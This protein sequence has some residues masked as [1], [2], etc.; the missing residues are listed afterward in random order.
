MKTIK[1]S[2]LT[3]LLGM[4]YYPQGATASTTDQLREGIIHYS[5]LNDENLRIGTQK[6]EALYK[7]TLDHKVRDDLITLLVR[8]GRYKDAIA[9]CQECQLTQ[10]SA[11]EL[12]HLAKAARN[13]RQFELAS[14]FYTQ[15]S[16][17]A[18]DNPNGILGLALVSIERPDYNAANH[19]LAKYKKQFGEDAQYTEAYIYLLDSSQP[20]TAR[21]T[22]WQ[23]EL[24]QHP[25]NTELAKKIYR[26][27]TQLNISP[28]QEKLVAA[29]PDLFNENDKLWFLHDEAIRLY[30]VATTRE[31][32]KTAYRMLSDANSR[33][34]SDD[35]GELKLQIMRDMVVVASKLQ[36]STEI[37]ATYAQLQQSGQPI[38]AFVKEAYA[39]Y[40][41][42]SG[43]PFSAL[44]IYREIETSHLQ[45]KQ[46]VPFA[47]GMKIVSA[48]SDTAE[49]EEAQHYLENNVSEPPVYVSDFTHSRKVRNPLFDEYF[50]GKV[51]LLAWRGDIDKAIQLIDERLEKTPG[52]AWMMLRKSE[53]ENARM[54][55]DDALK[56]ADNAIAVLGT[57]YRWAEVTRANI[58]LSLNDW[59]T[60]SSIIN[61]LTPE[62]RHA[63][64]YVVDQYEQAKSARF[65]ASVDVDH[66]THPANKPNEVAQEYYLYS[67]KSDGGHDIYA[68]YSASKSPDLEHKFEQHRV[69]V[70]ANINFYPVATKAEIGKGIKLNDKYYLSL[71]TSY[72]LNQHWRFNL[73]GNLNGSNTPVKAI[74]QDVYAKDIGFVTH[75]T[76]SNL[77]QMTAHINAMK[78]DDGNLRKN[79]SVFSTFNLFKHDRWNLDGGLFWSYQRNKETPSAY[80]YNP[81]RAQSAE[82]N[83]DLSYFKPFDH[84][85]NL[86][87]HLKG[88]VGRYW[89]DHYASHK[90]WFVTYGNEWRLGK[91]L[92]LS[93]ELGR[94]KSVYDGVP[95]FNNFIKTDL[96]VYF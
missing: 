92:G 67:P 45:E 3:V 62:E 53:L 28:L 51:N 30:R 36:N 11:N 72:R 37:E 56:W 21:L 86:V 24:K 40:L 57:N 15:L 71:D 76:H 38:P 75:Y 96:S 70:G 1:F 52:D 14:T 6:L 2:T 82:G 32:Q 65:V 68:H 88:G 47:L 60:A 34:P 43:S 77:F 39:D 87:H 90:T 18:P 16:K 59:K 64:K 66:R 78:F 85:I 69:G 58:A 5:R 55:G 12:E 25:D 54:R 31:Q 17:A 27:A 7:D 9:L 13:E 50:L 19:Y 49:F 74:Y 23:N 33:I 41:L 91:K 44:N 73:Y 8:Q 84:R 80:Y 94:K 93:Y 29:Y 95:E 10:Y 42:R 46:K 20:L 83:F 35:I 79:L 48:L 61:G 26:L 89:Q 4:I 81:L 63:A 22:R